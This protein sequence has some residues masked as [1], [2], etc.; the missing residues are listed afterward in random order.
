MTEHLFRAETA[1]LGSVLHEPELMDDIYLQPE[2]FVDDRHRLM[3]QYFRVMYEQDGTLDIVLMA[4]RSGKDLEKIG[5]VSYIMQVRGSVAGPE[6]IAHYQAI[7]RDGYIR[8]RTEDTLRLIADAGSQDAATAAEYVSRAQAALE[9]IAEIKAGPSESGVQRM[10]A[11]LGDHHK[12]LQRR[13]QQRGITGA[14]TA[15][16]DLDRLT[17]GHQPSDLEIIAA[18]P[19]MGK[20]AYVVNDMIAAAKGGHHTA[21]F[22]LEMPAK[23]IAERFLSVLGNIDGK[24]MKSG[25]FTDADWERWS[26]AMDELDRLPIFIDDTAGMTFQ[27]ISREVKRLVKKNPNLVIYIDFL[28]LVQTEQRFKSDHE[29][30]A[31]VSKGLKQLGRRFNVPVV[32]IS[33]VGRDCEKRQDKRPMMSDLRESGSIESDADNI[34]FLYRDDY[35]NS[36][37]DKKNIVEVIVAKGRD[38]GVGSIEM[39]FNKQTGRFLDITDEDRRK[40]A[41][42][43]ERK[44]N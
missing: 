41:E 34:I 38:V 11:A 39:A 15:S 5:N 3:L 37:S 1:V 29:R 9:E 33:A 12:E 23:R 13:S 16:A 4:A 31:Y 7:I 28:Q 43:R 19:S 18:R 2:E 22:S 10:S 27:H 17:G 6:N 44:A 8:R 36:D 40:A 30:I 14:R 21:L 25:A 32:A 26:F 20:T 42:A 35:Y 24:K